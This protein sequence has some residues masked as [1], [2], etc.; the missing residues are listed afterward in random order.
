MNTRDD[1]VLSTAQVSNVSI[2]GTL[3]GESA[4]SVIGVALSSTSDKAEFFEGDSERFAT[5]SLKVVDLD[6]ND[7]ISYEVESLTAT[8]SLGTYTVN[9]TYLRDLMSLTGE[10]GIGVTEGQLQ[11][12]FESDYNDFDYLAAGET[13][14]LNYTVSATD[15]SGEANNKDTHIITIVIAGTNDMPKIDD[16]NNLEQDLI[17]TNELLTTTGTFDIIDPDQGNTVTMMVDNFSA[18]GD[19]GPY[20]SDDP[21][22]KNLITFPNSPVVTSGETFGVSTW[23]FSADKTIFDYLAEGE[24]IEL[25]YDVVTV[26]NSSVADLNEMSTSY[27]ET[28]VIT[29][30]GTDDLPEFSG[31]L[32]GQVIEGDGSTTLTTSGQAIVNDPDSPS[33][34]FET[35]VTPATG[36]LGSLSIASNGQWTYSLNNDL[37][38]SFP[39]GQNLTENFTVR[40]TDG[41][42]TT[43]TI[44]VVG[45]NDS[46]Q[47]TGNFT[48]QVIEDTDF[49]TLTTSGQIFVTD[50]DQN[51]ASFD[52]TVSPAAGTLGSL[53][54]DT[55][56]QWT[57]SL[58]NN[59]VNTLQT[60]DTLTELFTI[61]S[62]DG[63]EKTI[64]ITVI[65]QNEFN[66]PPQ[67]V[68]VTVSTDNSPSESSSIVVPVATQLERFFSNDSI[69]ALQSSSS[70]NFNLTLSD[71]ALQSISS[72]LN[73]NN[74]PE[75]EVAEGEQDL[76]PNS[77]NNYI[78]STLSIEE[79]DFIQS[80]IQAA[81]ELQ[82]I[83]F[84]EETEATEGEETSF[85]LPA[86]NFIEELS[87]EIILEEKTRIFSMNE[88]DE[89]RL[90]E[91]ALNEN[92][93]II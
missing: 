37:V 35:T 89:R 92:F 45:Q 17:E 76:E 12:S 3:L 78:K 72:I 14:T 47:F 48:S 54:I 65:G 39:E 68:N 93:S 46:A 32:I 60:G 28:I 2:N 38:D 9:D 31:D 26:D 30:T 85:N 91:E 19:L 7:T 41:R 63:T 88:L 77:I 69:S 83:E 1:I 27:S 53:N 20:S 49:N 5:G 21:I 75:S 25:E 80:L 82:L 74:S 71:D 29:I 43:I 70:L 90:L 58:N 59:L 16:Y 24:V 73:L 18:F 34:V 66:L 55:N 8:G 51:Q 40:S 61:R 42:E 36:T 6:A 22:L 56:G 11:W 79:Q 81:E 13:L 87:A 86:F 67:D 52:T 15:D 64:T 84:T 57:Y 10:F 62:V 44:T 33:P 23:T 50:V 4:G